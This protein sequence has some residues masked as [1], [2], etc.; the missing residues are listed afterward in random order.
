MYAQVPCTN[1]KRQRGKDPGSP[2]LFHQRAHTTTAL[3]KRGKKKKPNGFKPRVAQLLMTASSFSPEGNQRLGDNVRLI[4]WA[5]SS[6]SVTGLTNLRDG[7]Q[8][9]CS[10]ADCCCQ[11]AEC[12]DIPCSKPHHHDANHCEQPVMSL[13]CSSPGPCKAGSRSCSLSVRRD[14][15]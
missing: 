1:T 4:R 7:A 15:V 11:A 12:A 5:F 3:Q 10:I 14:W 2:S 13:T 9:M 8:Y 6:R